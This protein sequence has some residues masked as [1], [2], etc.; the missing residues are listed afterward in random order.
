[1]RTHPALP[2][3]SP[4]N[5]Q[6]RFA[7]ERLSVPILPIHRRGL[8]ADPTYVVLV[9]GKN[10]GKMLMRGFTATRDAERCGHL[11]DNERSRSK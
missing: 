11:H 5:K 6:R 7:N 10:A 2:E 3:R 1:L 4:G 9:A 8:P